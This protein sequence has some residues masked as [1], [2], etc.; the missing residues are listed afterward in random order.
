LPTTDR[1][2]VIEASEILN[3][4]PKTVGAAARTLGW[5]STQDGTA[6]NAKKLYLRSDVEALAA[7]RRDNY[8]PIKFPYKSKSNKTRELIAWADKLIKWPS[9]KAI[10]AHTSERYT[11]WGVESVIDTRVF[12]KVDGEFMKPLREPAM[13][14]ED[15]KR[16]RNGERTD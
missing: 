3:L 6:F 14:R 15:V 11:V 7:N 5:E 9:D 8:S 2:S 13:K 16:R 4:C 1:I 12:R 10:K